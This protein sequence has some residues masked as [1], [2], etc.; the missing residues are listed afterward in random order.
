MEFKFKNKNEKR[1]RKKERKKQTNQQRYEVGVLGRW[2]NNWEK[3][4]WG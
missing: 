2:N 1:R 3:V 4:K